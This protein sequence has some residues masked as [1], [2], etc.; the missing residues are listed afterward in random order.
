MI[1]TADIPKHEIELIA[2]RASGPGGQ[3][4]NKVSSAIHLRF[5][6][7]RSSLPVVV[8]QRLIHLQDH[9]ISADGVVVIK[10]QNHRSQEKNRME[11]LARLD[12]LLRQVQRIKKVR[13][14]T[15][16][17]RSSIRKSLETK[18]KQSNQKK[19]R[20]KVDY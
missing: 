2:I 1:T 10:A 4:V 12:E 18:R 11:A 7:A 6:I 17:S 8:K 16:P 9:R 13:K 14:R 19:L 20:G 5:D 15:R 3:H